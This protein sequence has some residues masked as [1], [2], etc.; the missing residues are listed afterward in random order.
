MDRGV[1]ESYTME[2]TAHTQ[3]ETGA[4]KTR[5]GLVGCS[6]DFLHKG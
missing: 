4:E 3:G 1:A 5:E 2:V 6:K